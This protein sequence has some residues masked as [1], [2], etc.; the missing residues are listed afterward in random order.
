MGYSDD[1]E[2]FTAEFTSYVISWQQAHDLEADGIIGPKTWT[3]L[4]GVQP[5]V[6]TN[7]N[8]QCAAVRALQLILG[9]NLTPD[10][11]FGLRTQAAVTAFQAAKGLETDGVCGA[12]TWRAV[13]T[14]EGA[15][16]VS[17]AF[18]QPVDY[19][20]GDSRWGSKMYSNHGDSGQ[21]MRN[22][23]CG[24]TAAA[25]IVATLIDPS[26]TPYDLA[27]LSMQWGT[28]TYSSGTSWDFF[29]KLAERYGFAKMVQTAS[30]ET[31]KAC[32]DAGGY[33]VCSMAPGYWTKGGHFIC[34]WKY[35]GTY[36]YCN[37]PASSKRTKQKLSDFMKERKQFF[38][39]WR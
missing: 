28:R 29:G 2:T 5:T 30:L 33:A 20:Q 15:A 32:L 24:P 6:S 14:G 26:V 27:A 35:D 7:R 10:G 9:G 1:T 25:D 36:I 17:S 3:A 13:I 38:C 39:F 4:S 19:K 11:V 21:T 18:K 12:K 34:A 22:S 31:L 8:R 16:T 23:G 37:D